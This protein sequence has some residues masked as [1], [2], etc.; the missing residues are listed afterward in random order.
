ML[1]E[2]Q[3]H[4]FE[5]SLAQSE[6]SSHAMSRLGPPAATHPSFVVHE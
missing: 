6:G 4:T 2:G 3:Q 5:P 1:A